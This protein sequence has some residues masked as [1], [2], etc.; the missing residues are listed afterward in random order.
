MKNQSEREAGSVDL[1]AL[2]Q[3]IV[4]LAKSVEMLREQVAEQSKVI[5]ALGAR[6]DGGAAAAGQAPVSGS[7]AQEK[8]E[9]V[10]PEILLVIAAAVTAFLGKKVRIRSAKM[11][12]SPYEIINPWAQQGRVSVQASHRLSRG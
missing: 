11:L 10:E 6:L 1:A 3:Q 12:Q 5:A 7:R 9:A 8:E 2:Q 4:S